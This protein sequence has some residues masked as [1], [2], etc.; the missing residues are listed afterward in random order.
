MGAHLA[1]A[2]AG[3]LFELYYW[4]ERNREV[5]FVVRAGRTLAAIE[6]KSSRARDAQP[7]LTSFSDAFKPKRALLVG[8]DGIPLEEFLA[9]PAGHWVGA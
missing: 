8:G 6:V 9:K 7:G 1:N 5:D 3:G 4:R 2:A